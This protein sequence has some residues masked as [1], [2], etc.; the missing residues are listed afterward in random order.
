MISRVYQLGVKCFVTVKYDIGLFWYRTF[1]ELTISSRIQYYI[2]DIYNKNYS[3]NIAA[4]K[5]CQWIRY[6][7]NKR[8]SES[9]PI[10][11][12][13]IYPNKSL[14]WIHRWTIQL[15]VCITKKRKGRDISQQPLQQYP[16]Q[17]RSPEKLLGQAESE[18]RLCR[19]HCDTQKQPEYSKG[20]KFNAS[21][22]KRHGPKKRR[23]TG[24]RSCREP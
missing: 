18:R 4:G 22:V 3:R 20:V 17:C 23:N 5:R 11:L 12:Q 21:C 13:N 8:L 2:Y 9:S 10:I 14:G 6:L 7:N 1:Y 19:W 16:E 15:D 24:K